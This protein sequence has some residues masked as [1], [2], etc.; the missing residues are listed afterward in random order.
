MSLLQDWYGQDAESIASEICG[1]ITVLTGTVILH[2]TREEEQASSGRARWQESGKSF[3]EEH[4]VRLYSPPECQESKTLN[5]T[6][7]LLN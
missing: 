6:V 3:N 5:K 2:A 7:S 1:F 4:L